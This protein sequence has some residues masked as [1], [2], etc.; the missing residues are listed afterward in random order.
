MSRYVK[1]ADKLAGEYPK[2]ARYA[3][4]FGKLSATIESFLWFADDCNDL[5]LLKKYV[6]TG[7]DSV[8]E[9]FEGRNG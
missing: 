9:A 5:E 4:A 6:K 3:A 1:S 2:E 7:F 8:T